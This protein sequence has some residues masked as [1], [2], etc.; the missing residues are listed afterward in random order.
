M[1]IRLTVSGDT[2]NF[3]LTLNATYDIN[4]DYK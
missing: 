1:N 2:V 4:K 3:L